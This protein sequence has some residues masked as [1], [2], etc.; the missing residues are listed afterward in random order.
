MNTFVPSAKTAFFSFVITVNVSENWREGIR[1]GYPFRA[2]NAIIPPAGVFTACC[3]TFWHHS[4][5]TWSLWL[6]M[7]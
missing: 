4:N 5:I 6:W 1:S 7:L 2:I 3:R